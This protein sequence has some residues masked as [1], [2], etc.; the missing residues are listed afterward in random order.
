[1]EI[2]GWLRK[3]HGLGHGHAIAIY[4]TFKGKKE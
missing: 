3:D 2:V 4:A 1:M